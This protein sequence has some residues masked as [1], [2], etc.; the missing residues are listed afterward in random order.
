M[1]ERRDHVSRTG[2]PLLFLSRSGARE[3]LLLS[4]WVVRC[5]MCLRKRKPK[6]R[7][8]DRRLDEAIR[9]GFAVYQKWRWYTPGRHALLL[10]LC[11]AVHGWEAMCSHVADVMEAT[12]NR[13]TEVLMDE[14]NALTDATPARRRA[15]RLSA[16]KAERLKTAPARSLFGVTESPDW[17][18][19]VSAQSAERN[20][21]EL[22]NVFTMRKHRF[23][24]AG[25]FL[26]IEQSESTGSICS[27]CIEWSLPQ[28]GGQTYNWP[29]FP[30]DEDGYQEGPTRGLVARF[31]EISTGIPG[32]F[33]AHV[34]ETLPRDP[35]PMEDTDGLPDPI[36]LREP[37]SWQKILRFLRA[38]SGRSG[39]RPRGFT[40]ELSYRG[41]GFSV[42]LHEDERARPLDAEFWWDGCT[43]G[44]G[45]KW[46]AGRGLR[47]LDEVPRSGLAEQFLAA[48]G[49]LPEG[50]KSFLHGLLASLPRDAAALSKFQA[51]FKRGKLE[52]VCLTLS[53]RLQQLRARMRRPFTVA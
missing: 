30:G 32:G 33:R 24:G 43:E 29:V 21:S 17:D 13:G 9:S 47:Y 1:K 15:A 41:G 3:A 40:R 4:W 36:D 45:V 35:G 22:R 37:G 23:E 8:R 27:Y 11:L 14:L 46:R 18:E 52:V 7:P 42:F 19:W 39:L 44:P 16:R 49:T 26:R 5:R 2:R 48:S 53:H 28:N 6:D 10:E 20:T 38:V 25:F 51:R 31:A 12:V 50:H 34:I